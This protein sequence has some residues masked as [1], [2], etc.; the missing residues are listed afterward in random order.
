MDFVFETSQVSKWPA[1][2]IQVKDRPLSEVLAMLLTDKNLQYQIDNR[3]ITIRSRSKA[4]PVAQRRIASQQD[5]EVVGSVSAGEQNLYG[6]TVS[7]K[8]RTSGSTTTDANGRY[9]IVVPLHATLLFSHVGY[10]TVEKTLGDDHRMDVIMEKENNIEEVV[11]VGFGTQKKVSV[12]GALESVKPEELR[13][14]SA[15]LSNALAGRLA[16]VIAVQRSGEPGADGASFY[17]RGIST[18]SGATNPLILLDGVSI[19]Q[20]DFNAIA[21]ETIES[22]SLLQDATATAI[23]GTRGANGVLIVTTK[24]GKNLDKPRVY[25]RSQSQLSRPTTIP[26]FVDGATYMELFN[27]TVAGRGTGEPLYTQER[28]DGTRNRLDPYVFPDV[29]WLEE[30]FKPHTINNELNFN[31]QGGGSKVGYFLSA[32]GNNSNGILRNFNVN[33]FDNN[34]NVNRYSFQNNINADVTPTT[35]VALKLNAQ[36]RDYAGPARTASSLYGDVMNV[37]PVD[38]P[39]MFPMTS[40]DRRDVQYGGRAGGTFNNGF[41]NPFGDMVNGYLDGFESTVLITIDGAQK[42]DFVTKGLEFKALASFKNYSQ[43]FVRRNSGYNQFM[44]N[45]FR[46]NPAG[47]YEYELQMVG[48]PQN[49]A[50]GTATESNGNRET[51]WQ[52]SIDYN[53]KFGAHDVSAMI[54]YNQTDYNNN[55]PTNNNLIE[56][57]P[58]RRQGI[59]ARTTYGYQDRYLV[60][61]NF[62]YNGSENFAAGYRWG[63]FPSVGLGYV[64]S[65]EKFFQQLLPSVSLLKFRGTW[66]QVGNDLIGGAR[67]PY[68]SDL[69]LTGT[70]FTTGIDQNTNYSGPTYLQF[71]NPLMTWE[72]ADKKNLGLD[73]SFL[74]KTHFVINFFQEDRTNIFADISTTI[75]GVFGTSG[76]RVF[77]NVGEVRNRGFDMSLEHGAKLGQNWNLSMRGT[78]TFARNTIVK[79]NEPAFTRYQNLSAIGH[80][81]G[82]PL[83]YVAERLFIDQA[84]IDN[85]ATQQLG[86]FVAAGDI[87]YTNVT[88]D[89]DGLA[90]INGDDRVR[91]GYPAVP[92]I[93]YGLSTTLRYKKLDLSFLLQGVGRTSFMLGGFHPFGTQGIRNVLQ[94]IADER[95]TPENP[96]VFASYPRLSKLDNPNNTQA[97][98]YWLRDASF[99]KLRSA[100]IGYSYKFVR[101]FASGFNLLTFSKFK[102]WDPEQGGGNG[103]GYPTQQVFN[104]GLQMRFN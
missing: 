89:I 38:F 50:L 24:S 78:F 27:E 74:N 12:V 47:Q 104:L 55:A 45:D 77:S 103:L 37:N 14:P 44:V 59:T 83:G 19:T 51:Y 31:I 57:L 33:S 36:L 91:M 65:N 62:A 53:R 28:I 10:K 40:A 75:P 82:T 58:H 80:P 96:N 35:K 70:S 25:V 72:H 7:V 17:V 66:G 15:N 101:A 43:T 2:T 63:F 22:V 4:T 42:L 5:V 16:G 68:L 6:V 71:A 34:I 29:N 93:T 11:V 76:T 9:I 21:P 97:S 99:L 90:I 85:H 39:I 86:G 69:N 3:I 102:L 18:F 84:E 88:A 60:E 26:N 8:G 1:T 13:I 67:F 32:T 52:P 87:K 41:R 95:W 30:M 94:F 20:D 46:V 54:L 92:E 56:S 81:I 64:L 49:L 48:Q 79:N 23:F 73:L 100:E 98:T 61:F